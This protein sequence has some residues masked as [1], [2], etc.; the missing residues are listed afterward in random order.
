MENRNSLFHNERT[1][2]VY[3][4]KQLL[5]PVIT[6]ERAA[7]ASLTTAKVASAASLKLH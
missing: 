5:V 2:K 7:T 1:V 4:E 6:V 3:F